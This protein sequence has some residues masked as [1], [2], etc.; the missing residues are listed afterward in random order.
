MDFAKTEKLRLSALR[1]LNILDTPSDERF[2][3]LTNIAQRFYDVPVALFTLVDEK[4]QW[5]KSKQ[6]LDVTET[7]RSVA[8]CDHA[9]RGDTVFIV[10]DARTD[11]RFKD[12]PLVTGDPFIRFYAGMPVREPGGFKIGT[13]CIIDYEPRVIQGVHRF[14]KSSWAV[15]HGR[16]GQKIE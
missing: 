3:R 14:R 12:N 1:K 6:G 13:L 9:I 8:F 2:E 15:R 7:P 10:E 4:R 5:F 16:C 11:A